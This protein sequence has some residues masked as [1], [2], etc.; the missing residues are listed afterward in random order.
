MRRHGMAAE[1]ADPVSFRLLGVIEVPPYLAVH[2]GPA[3]GTKI[4][5]EP[6]CGGGSDSATLVHDS[7]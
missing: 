2:P 5:G 6:E 4:S 3:G 7:F 1:A